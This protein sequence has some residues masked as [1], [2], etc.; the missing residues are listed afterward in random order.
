MRRNRCRRKIGTPDVPADM[1][2][3]GNAG[4][5]INETY[6]GA[7]KVMSQRVLRITKMRVVTGNA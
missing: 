4:A 2:G 6:T 7:S 3:N 5:A 1:D